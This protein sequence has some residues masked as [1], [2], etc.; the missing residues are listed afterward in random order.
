MNISISDMI[1]RDTNIN[2]IDND[3]KKKYQIQAMENSNKIK[4]SIVDKNKDVCIHEHQIGDIK[5]HL[6]SYT[7]SDIDI[8]NKHYALLGYIIKNAN[9]LGTIDLL[10]LPDD[11]LI[12]AEM[13]GKFQI[14]LINADNQRKILREFSIY[15]GNEKAVYLMT[16]LLLEVLEQMLE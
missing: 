9:I 6:I 13:K 16:E 1:R 5:C 8:E 2:I 11:D 10:F 14:V 12:K 4:I 15:I 3:Q 7:L